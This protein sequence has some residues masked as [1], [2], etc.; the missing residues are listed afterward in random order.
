MEKNEILQLILEYSY[1][2]AAIM[3]VVGLKF[4]SHPETSKK[5]NF[6]AASGMVLA[7]ITTLV[8][9]KNESGQNIPLA[10]AI[11]VIAVISVGTVVGA[12][13]ARRVKMTAMPQLVSFY[14]ATGGL[15]SALVAFMEFSNPNNSSTLVTVLGL[16][17][18]SIAFSG[19]MIAYGKLDGKVGDW[20]NSALTYINLVI[21]I[22]IIGGVIY[23]SYA[24][25]HFIS[26]TTLF[27]ILFA[28][29]LV[30]GV[31]FVMPIGGADMP[32]VIS[33]LNSLTG[34]AAAM[35]GFIY[36]N[37]AMILGGILV[38]AAGTILTVLMW[39]CYESLTH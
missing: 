5:G 34:I 11:L 15:A 25:N 21:L 1:L 27:Y 36:G 30:Y 35:A 28:V 6:W 39:P 12:V 14:N 4:M 18:G 23:I 24:T 26:V 20:F 3:F 32:V 10:N 16:V 13:I 37:R 19:S 31:L 29:A 7:M 33:L 22:S 9:H 17:I 38:G 2:I 8:L